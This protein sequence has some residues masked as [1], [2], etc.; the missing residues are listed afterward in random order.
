MSNFTWNPLCAKDFHYEV[1]RLLTFCMSTLYIL[2][3]IIAKMSKLL[4]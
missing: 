4:K 1:N 2:L 3:E